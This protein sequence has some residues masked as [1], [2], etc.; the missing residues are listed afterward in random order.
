MAQTKRRPAAAKPAA[1]EVTQ[2]NTA[3]EAGG[4]EAKEAEESTKPAEDPTPPDGAGQVVAQAPGGEAGAEP[5]ANQQA[6]D[7]APSP[8]SGS[9]EDYD[10]PASSQVFVRTYR[11]KPRRRA[12]VAFGPEPIPLTPSIFTNEPEAL[13]EALRGMLAIAEDPELYVFRIDADG[14]EVAISSEDIADLREIVAGAEAE[15]AEAAAA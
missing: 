6:E 15:A 7:G 4:T 9:A 13:L 14:N 3:P 11:N 10:I 12:G 1:Q 8:V 5:Q 2:A